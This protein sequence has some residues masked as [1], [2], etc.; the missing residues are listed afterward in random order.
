[1]NETG[2]VSCADGNTPYIASYVDDNTPY[3]VGNNVED[4]I[5]N[6]QNA[7]R[8]LFQWFYEVIQS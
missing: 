8:T 2:F 7:L 1:M 3:V 4:V 5:T 6:L